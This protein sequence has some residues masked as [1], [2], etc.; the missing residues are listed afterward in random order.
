MVPPIGEVGPL[1]R[2]FEFDGMTVVRWGDRVIDLHNDYDLEGFGTDLSGGEVKLRFRRN[3]HAYDPDNLPA[4]AT[5]TCGG[6]VRVA[7]N[8]LSAI[9]TRL[10]D[11]GIE[12]AYFNEACGWLSYLDEGLARRQVPQGLYVSFVNGFAVRI[13]CDE[14]IFATQ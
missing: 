12:I 7:F 1:K 5:L 3:A 2:N 9:A 8:D 4:T 10:D 13:F 14:A 6:N 11:E